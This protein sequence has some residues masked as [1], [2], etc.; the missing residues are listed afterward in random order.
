MARK[1]AARKTGGKAKSKSRKPAPKA[2]SKSTKRKG[3][4][5]GGNDE[6]VDVGKSIDA[7][8]RAT[9]E[10]RAACRKARKVLNDY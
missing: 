7:I 4:F 9:V 1:K 3:S 6:I 8:E 5:D 10:L 2:R